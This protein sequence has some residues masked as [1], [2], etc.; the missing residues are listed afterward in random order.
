MTVGTA[1]TAARGGIVLHVEESH[2]DGQIAATGFDN[3]L[4][5]QH[6]DGTAALYG[7]FTH[8]GVV[9]SVGDSVGPG[10]LVGYSGNTGNTANKPTLHFSVQTCDPVARGTAACPTVPVN[11]RNTDANPTG[12]QVG[13][14]YEAR[15]Y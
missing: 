1:V 12:L 15:P 5:I 14:T 8:D 6:E 2:F 10:V 7:H 9:V 4:V 13:R 11:F 3:I